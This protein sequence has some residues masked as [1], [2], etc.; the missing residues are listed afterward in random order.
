MNLFDSIFGRRKEF[1]V[2]VLV[3]AAMFAAALIVL[4]FIFR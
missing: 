4:R 2:G 1:Y 3:L